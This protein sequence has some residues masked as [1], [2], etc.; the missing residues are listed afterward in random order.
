MINCQG[1]SC[2]NQFVIA[3]EFGGAD[4]KSSNIKIFDYRVL[5]VHRDVEIYDD[6]CRCALCV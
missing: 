3:Q 2:F 1:L 5:I 4:K 6:I